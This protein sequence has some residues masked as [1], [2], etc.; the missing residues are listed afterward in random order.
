[1]ANNPVKETI[2]YIGNSLLGTHLG[3]AGSI[4]ETIFGKGKKSVGRKAPDIYD[5]IA[6]F[7]GTDRSNAGHLL[8]EFYRENGNPTAFGGSLTSPQNLPFFENWLHNQ[9][10]GGGKSNTT[11][12]LHAQ[13][14][15]TQVVQPYLQHVAASNNDYIKNA[16]NTEAE[17]AK[18]F[19]VSNKDMQNI[20]NQGNART[21]AADT[22]LN[23]TLAQQAALGPFLDQLMTQLQATR[24]QQQNLWLNGIP[25]F[26]QSQTPPWLQAATSGSAS[27]IGSL[28]ASQL[29]QPTT[30]TP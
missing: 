22:E 6:Q 24:Q 30:P 9:T 26:T 11:D 10:S 8:A 7:T 25:N 20:I 4:G 28:L 2:D 5:Q 17:V 19:P 16:Q 14:F 15:F 13:A 3:N 23:N 21:A 12:P 18:M 29:S 1:M 27:G